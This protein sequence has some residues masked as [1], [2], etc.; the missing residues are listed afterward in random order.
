MVT[1]D[2]RFQ[3][4]IFEKV[5]EFVYTGSYV[6]DLIQTPGEFD[7]PAAAMLPLKQVKNTLDRTDVGHNT[8]MDEF[9][10]WTSLSNDNF[11]REKQ[12][13][14]I[15]NSGVDP[16]I[17]TM[18]IAAKVYLMAHTLRIGPLM[19]LAYGRLGRILRDHV[20]DA[21]VEFFIPVVAD[22]YNSAPDDFVLQEICVQ[23]IWKTYQGITD[24]RCTYKVQ[25]PIG[26]GLSK[27]MMLQGLLTETYRPIDW[28]KLMQEHDK[29]NKEDRRI[30]GAA[31]MLRALSKPEGESDIWDPDSEDASEDASE[32][33]KEDDDKTVKAS[34]EDKG[35]TKD[36][37]EEDK[38]ETKD[39]SEEDKKGDS[40]TGKASADVKGKTKEVAEEGD[41]KTGKASEEGKGETK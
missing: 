8:F 35:A 28:V 15:R 18:Y 2:K 29:E 32:D 1:L 6:D 34:E 23:Y 9:F 24:W 19:L 4:D 11:E 21:H 38:G 12:E 33:D 27:Y 14:R 16:I 5:V 17:R 30:K 31:A 36:A 40:K 26:E 25:G 41:G 22:I 13:E 3:P 7:I 37:S 10:P 39:A 20:T